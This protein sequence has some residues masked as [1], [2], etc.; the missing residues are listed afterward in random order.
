MAPVVKEVASGT[1][2]WIRLPRGCGEQT[3]MGLG[4]TVFAGRY[5]KQTGQMTPEL[6]RNTHDFISKGE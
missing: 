1:E 5:L 2:K 6:E 3:M 4:P